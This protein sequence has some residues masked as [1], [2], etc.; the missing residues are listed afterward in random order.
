M[1]K[2]TSKIHAQNTCTKYQSFCLTG[3]DWLLFFSFFCNLWITLFFLF[4]W[5]SLEYVS[6]VFLV[7][8]CCALSKSNIVS[9]AIFP[10]IF[11]RLIWSKRKNQFFFFFFMTSKQDL[12]EMSFHSKYIAID[13]IKS[14]PSRNSSLRTW[15]ALRFLGVVDDTTGWIMAREIY[16]YIQLKRSQIKFGT[17][18]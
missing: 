16:I 12:F 8:N 18:S 7:I 6:L 17:N 10:F 1:F 3:D 5:S 15:F 11:F 9:V 4:S 13:L 2:N 14:E